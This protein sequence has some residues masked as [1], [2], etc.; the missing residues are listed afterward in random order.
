MSKAQKYLHEIQKDM[1]LQRTPPC[2]DRVLTNPEK[3]RSVLVRAMLFGY[4]FDAKAIEKFAQDV[5]K[6]ETRWLTFA[7]GVYHAKPIQENAATT[8]TQIHE[9]A[10]L[11]IGDPRIPIATWASR[12]LAHHVEMY[13]QC[14][15]IWGFDVSQW[16]PTEAG[17]QRY[18]WPDGHI[19]PHR[20]RR[21]DQLLGA[22]L[23]LE[24]SAM[25][26]IHQ[27]KDDPNDYSNLELINEFETRPGSL[28]LLRAPGGGNGKQVI[29]EVLPPKKGRRLVL[30]LRMRPD[31][32]KAP[33]EE[34]SHE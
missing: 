23:T 16:A 11:P 14:S 26:K 25:V 9:R 10:Y 15:R 12:A 24:G 30:N 7:R 1:E 5:L 20:D 21:S 27:P 18:D 31:V 28:M 22:T 17:Y 3:F 32:L 19:S 33:S 6:R 29:H 13:G 34:P 2:V 8:V 4:A